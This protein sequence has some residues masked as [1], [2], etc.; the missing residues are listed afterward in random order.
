LSLP[1]AGLFLGVGACSSS[2]DNS[3]SSTHDAAPSPPPGA[4][5]ISA[6]VTALCEAGAPS[7][8]SDAGTSDAAAD[9]DGSSDSGVAVAPPE[10]ENACLVTS[11]TSIACPSAVG[12]IAV[13]QGKG[14]A[15]DLLVT[16]RRVGHYT[17]QG[18]FENDHDAYVQYVRLDGHGGGNATLD[19]IP[20]YTVPIEQPGTAPTL[21]LV[22][23]GPSADSTLALVSNE[24]GG[25]A[26][27]MGSGA[28]FVVPGSFRPRFAE[29]GAAEGMAL[30]EPTDP[31]NGAPTRAPLVLV[32]GL[33]NAPRSIPTALAPNDFVLTTDPSG[34]PAGLFTTG[35]SVKLLEG[36][37]FT[38]ERWSQDRSTS[39]ASGS[40]GF[41]LAYVPTA[42]GAVPAVLL[43][44]TVWFADSGGDNG[45]AVLGSSF[46][47]CSRN[48]Y[49][50]VTCDACPV[51]QHCETGEDDIRSARLFTQGGKLFAIYLS[52]DV[53]RTMGFSLDKTPIINV[54]C[55]CAIHERSKQ[56]FADSIVVVEIVPATQ[57]TGAPTVVEHMR[58]P[59]FKA[60]TTGFLALSPRTDG[61]VDVVV[62]DPLATSWSSGLTEPPKAP[63]AFRAIR[64]STKLLH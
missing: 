35:T 20:P 49:V 24:N 34:N 11:D 50:G 36:E 56:E 3:S 7:A 32:R 21:A 38:S 29:S 54:G 4:C 61:D 22:A 31:T 15:L 13:A 19:P 17:E 58:L 37:T 16:Q 53:R 60:R 18:F 14:D 27:R 28:P 2:S 40:G 43:A 45:H 64:I 52:T 1:F 30:L 26:F 42:T 9:G 62:G 6:T 44:N 10:S 46:S 47:T 12:A 8:P 63:A 55:V 57:A 48:T 23:G 51:D 59:L 25:T 41:D 5:T 33:P 39:S